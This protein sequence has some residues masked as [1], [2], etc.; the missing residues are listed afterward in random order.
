ME[1]D[2]PSSMEF[3]VDGQTL[4]RESISVAF[5]IDHVLVPL[6]AVPIVWT[7]IN[8]P[9]QFRHFSIVKNGV[10][11]AQPR[12]VQLIRAATWFSRPSVNL[13]DMWA[14]S[15]AIE[16]HMSAGEARFLTL[17]MDEQKV[18]F[19]STALFRRFALVGGTSSE[20]P[21]VP[22]CLN[23]S[24]RGSSSP[25]VLHPEW[26]TF[27][28][29]SLADAVVLQKQSLEDALMRFALH[30]PE[31]LVAASMFREKECLQRWIDRL[32]L[33]QMVPLRVRS[34]R[35]ETWFVI[36][37]SLDDATSLSCL[38]R[39]NSVLYASVVYAFGSSSRWSYFA[40][41]EARSHLIER[42]EMVAELVSVWRAVAKARGWQ[43]P[44]EEPAPWLRRLC[45]TSA[46]WQKG[47]SQRGYLDGVQVFITSEYIYPET[48]NRGYDMY[49]SPHDA[50]YF[51]TLRFILKSGYELEFSGEE[52]DFAS[53]R[54]RVVMH[55]SSNWCLDLL[56]KSVE[57]PEP[58]P[59]LLLCLLNMQHQEK[60]SIGKLLIRAARDDYG[61]VQDTEDENSYGDSDLL[62]DDVPD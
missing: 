62:T 56:A 6:K 27:L 5:L 40:A 13:P 29:E 36:A 23:T 20:E 59:V 44:P 38:M 3:V 42:P 32:E 21:T 37:R 58:F 51:I 43:E 55:E 31:F 19:D 26:R 35:D 53:M 7:V 41:V 25:P 10:N 54:V 46:F 11:E 33:R 18:H 4:N 12:L 48:L 50:R 45:V 47:E 15:S 52:Q 30:G 24:T 2:V 34:S 1:S 22:A 9:L 49:A 8:C 16:P 17:W 14:F 61:G 60:H 57:V 28:L 39:C